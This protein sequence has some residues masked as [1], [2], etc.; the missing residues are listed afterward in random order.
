[1]E[2]NRLTDGSLVLARDGEHVVVHIDT[3]DAAGGPDDLRGDET[4]F[5]GAAAEVEDGFAGAEITGWIAA[6][7]IALDYFGRDDFQVLTV[8]FDR[9]TEGFDARL[10]RIAVAITDGAFNIE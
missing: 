8:V 7:V 4:D 6:A 1:V 3:D 2:S 9:T 10:C 5:S